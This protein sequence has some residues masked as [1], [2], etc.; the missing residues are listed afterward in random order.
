MKN[1]QNKWFSHRFSN[2]A[3][4]S[5]PKGLVD[6]PDH[7]G[8]VERVQLV[9]GWKILN[10]FLIQVM[11]YMYEHILGVVH[12]WKLNFSAK[13]ATLL[14]QYD[15]IFGNFERHEVPRQF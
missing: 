6:G 11:F 15:M 4:K 1:A 13:G 3:Q 8:S 2:S 14:P 7:Q 12:W 5:T 10:F 9:G